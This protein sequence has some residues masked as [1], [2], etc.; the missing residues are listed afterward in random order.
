MA[1]PRII[2]PIVS[3][4][5]CALAETAQAAPAK[6]TYRNGPLLTAVEVYTIFWGAAW[7]QSPQI[8]LATELNRFFDF[9]LTS[10]LMDV[11]AEYSVPGKV[12]RHGRR[13]GATT[14]DDSEPGGSSGTVSDDQIQS[15]LKD[16][17]QQGRIPAVTSNTLYFVFLPPGVTSTQGGGKSCGTGSNDYC[18]YHNQIDSKIF[19]A[20]EPYID[21]SACTYAN[22]IGD[23]LTAVSSH[24]LCEAITDPVPGQGWYD[25]TYG[26]IGDICHTSITQLGGFTVQREWSNRGN[27]CILDITGHLVW[28]DWQ[29]VASGSQNWHGLERL[30]DVAGVAQVV[31]GRNTDGRLEV[32]ALDAAMGL[33]WHNWQNSPSGSQDW[34]GWEQLGG[35]VGLGQIAVSSNADGRLELFAW[36]NQTGLAWHVWQNSPSGSQDWHGWERLFDVVG[37]GQIAVGSNADGRLELFAL[38]T[39]AGL[40]WHNWQNS[41][42]GSQDWHGWER[43]FDAAG[44]GRIAV[45]SNAD[46]RL[47][48]FALDTSAGLIWHVWQNNPSGSQDWSGW[49][50]LGGGAGLVHNHATFS[51][52]IR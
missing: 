15:A 27:A 36:D 14:I 23:R 43:L 51:G 34:H 17:L 7:V 3:P 8:A 46:G 29:N 18:G 30:F 11:L 1:I 10:S 32:F 9:I 20:V 35:A 5:E 12:I 48:L 47:E 33:I 24:E 2:V 39:S 13:I 50:R 37:L 22:G 41:P 28:H 6:L 16:W 38:D 45:G 19:Y 31:V 4:E 21:C 25:D 40:A 42:S 44:L 26:E 52:I 49:E